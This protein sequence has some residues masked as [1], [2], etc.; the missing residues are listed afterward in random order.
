MKLSKER[1]ASLIEFM[2]AATIGVFAL[3]IIGSMFLSG[4]KTATKRTQELTLLQSTNSVLQ[5]MKLD[6][7]RAGYNGVSPNLVKLSGA[8]HTFYVENSATTGLL[9][10]A[11]VAE[12]SGASYTY[13]NVV[14]EQTSAA[15]DV[16]RICEKKQSTV[17]SVLDAQ[18]F[19]GRVGH[20]CNT[21]FHKD[22][23][24]VDGFN[25]TLVEL[26]GSNISSAMVTVELQT[27]LKNAPTY[28][29][30]LSF[31]TKQRNW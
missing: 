19:P 26:P 31:T 16:L 1:G 30:S 3:G 9:A 29:K 27:S 5:M 15:S 11:Y 14:Y 21:L 13:S 23:I 12:V 8:D 22:R 2:V 7:H 20:N 4:Y 10:Y 24:K 28:T 25:L 17:M 6:M 18:D